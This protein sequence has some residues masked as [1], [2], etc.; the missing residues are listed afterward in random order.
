ME[1]LKEASQKM[2][3]LKRAVVLITCNAE[4]AFKRKERSIAAT[5]ATLERIDKEL[6]AKSLMEL[7]FRAGSLNGIIQEKEESEQI[8][9]KQ[10]Q[11]LRN[12][13]YAKYEIMRTLAE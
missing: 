12:T 2:D 4:L 3:E 9:K 11:Q 6:A 8:S 1:A 7:D 13:L 5:K 10:A